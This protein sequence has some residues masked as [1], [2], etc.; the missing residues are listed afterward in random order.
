M[1]HFNPLLLLALQLPAP[2]VWAEASPD[3]Q[4]SWLSRPV[5]ETEASVP[6]PKMRDGEINGWW[7]GVHQRIVERA[8]ANPDAKLIFIGD[9]ITDLFD[10]DK[11][12]PRE[13]YAQHKGGIAVWE[14]YYAPRGALNA[15][16]SGDTT[17][18]VLW[19]MRNGLLDALTGPEVFVLT[20]GHNN[21]QDPET[22][23]SGMLALLKEMRTQFPEATIL[24]IPHF[25]T[26]GTSWSRSKQIRAYEIAVETVRGDPRILPLDLNGGFL[27]EAGVLKNPA[28]IPDNVHPAEPGYRAWAEGMEPILVE[29][30]GNPQ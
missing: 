24:F 10:S 25:P 9:S 26:T 15:G 2:Q 20:I 4:V 29:L 1:K 23:A 30:L 13:E 17:Q 18:A 21:K 8:R 11:Y 22:I 12:S 28:M 19:R 5:T 14:Q 27:N 7:E 6:I 16:I 3:N